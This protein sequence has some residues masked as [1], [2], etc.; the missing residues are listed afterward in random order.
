[1]Q[2]LETELTSE[3]NDD[4]S[5]LT[6]LNQQY[7]RIANSMMSGADHTDIALYSLSIVTLFARAVVGNSLDLEKVVRTQVAALSKFTSLA[8]YTF[9]KMQE[10]QP[11]PVIAPTKEDTRFRSPQWSENL[12]FDVV[13]QS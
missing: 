13:K 12:W 7:W 4:L 6:D 5:L 8:Q 3:S 10:G 9:E 1:M 11:D 2:K